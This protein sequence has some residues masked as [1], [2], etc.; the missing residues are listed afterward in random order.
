MP[1]DDF[2]CPIS[3]ELMTDPV[4]LATGQTFDRVSIQRWLD[5]GQVRCPMTKQMLYDTKLIPNY[6]LRSLINQWAE[7][8]GVELKKPEELTRSR[9]PKVTSKKLQLPPR[10]EVQTSV[11]EALVK[12]MSQGGIVE[13]REAVRQIRGLTNEGHEAKLCIAEAAAIPL[14]VKCLTCGDPQTEEHAF[15]ALLNLSVDDDWKVGLIAEGALEKIVQALEEGS[16]ETRVLAAVLL[17]SLAIV[18]VNK[19]TIGSSPD[20]IP[21]LVKLLVYGNLRG[22][23]DA[24]TALYNLCRY[25]ANKARAVAAGIVPAL[26]ALLK[27]GRS[28]TAERALVVLDL[29]STCAEGRAAIGQETAMASLVEQLRTG[30]N[31]SKENAAAVLAIICQNSP[32]ATR[33]VSHAGALEHTKP[34]LLHGTPRAKRK[35]SALIK[36]LKDYSP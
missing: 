32:Q 14:V 9:P 16:M 1:P 17:T 5:S 22:K 35:A 27:E 3:L 19:A 12:Q 13:R 36:C 11:V 15:G 7:T 6:A 8:N 31:Q 30:T 20:A 26:L 25:H 23:K 24:T 2:R 18:D 33:L 10:E 34:L 29:L 4:I 28:D 21:A